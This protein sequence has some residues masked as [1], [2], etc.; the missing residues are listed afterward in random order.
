MR[1]QPQQHFETHKLLLL[2]RSD[3]AIADL[4]KSNKL[5]V[6]A[7]SHTLAY[8]TD[9]EPTGPYG[10]GNGYNYT[11]FKKESITLGLYLLLT[12]PTAIKAL[13]Q[14]TKHKIYQD[15][16][17]AIKAIASKTQY[18]I[19]APYNIKFELIIANPELQETARVEL[20]SIENP[21]KLEQDIQTSLSISPAVAEALILLNT[22]SK[23]RE[24][25]AKTPEPGRP[26]SA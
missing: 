12:R 13:D 9:G 5:N 16:E 6:S 15:N 3:M 4:I 7:I 14:A 22:F 26:Y 19:A 2:T 20:H 8:A 24:T 25:A 17:T 23:K 18:E 1:R 10:T 11:H 21:G